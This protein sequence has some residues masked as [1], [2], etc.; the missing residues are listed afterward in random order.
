VNPPVNRTSPMTRSEIARVALELV[1]RDGVAAF[2]M[3]R[4]ADALGVTTMAVYH[5]F[6]NKAEVLQAA[7]DQVWVES[8]VTMPPPTDDPVEDL[9]QVM[10]ATRR[11]FLRHVEVTTF[12]FAPPTTEAAIHAITIGIVERFERAG[13]RDADVAY[14]YHA[15][16][17]YTLGSA[18]LHAERTI[19]ERQIRRPITDLDD[20]VPAD[21][22]VPEGSAEAYDAVREILGDDLDLVHFER[23]L[24]DITSGLVAR[25]VAG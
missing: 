16:A 24:R 25:Y 8:V 3:R 4:L 1:D 6:Q 12:A 2:S 21:L 19:L 17:T 22:A 18:L 7:A 5:H 9:V 10:L 23:G 11:A 20:Q 15:L 13:F 14:A